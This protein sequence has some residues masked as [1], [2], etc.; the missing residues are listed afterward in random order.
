MT[1][2]RTSRR[3]RTAGSAVA[4]YLTTAVLFAALLVALGA[5]V[6]AGR[7]PALGAAKVAQVAPRR[8]VIVRRVIVTHRKVIIR[9]AAAAGGGTAVVAAHGGASPASSA[10]PVAQAAPAPVSAPPPAPAVTKTS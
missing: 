10:P 1:D 9:P 7:D 6:A 2:A 3:S 5:G 8:E 4:V